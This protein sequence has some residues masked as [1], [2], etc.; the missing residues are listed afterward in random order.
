MPRVAVTLAYFD[1][2][3]ELKAELAT[4]YP[5]PS[6]APIANRFRKMN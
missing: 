4:L 3:P 6:S 2:F 1:F 5:T